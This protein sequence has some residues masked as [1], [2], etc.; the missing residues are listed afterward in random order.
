MSVDSAFESFRNAVREYKK[1]EA[2]ARVDDPP[3]YCPLDVDVPSPYESTIT[4]SSSPPQMPTSAEIGI[5][6]PAD[7]RASGN[8]VSVILIKGDFY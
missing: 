4:H 3:A 1:H 5:L 6:R 2:E 7:R 8:R